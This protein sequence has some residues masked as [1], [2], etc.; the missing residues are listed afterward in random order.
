[1]EHWVLSQQCNAP[2]RGEG[3]ARP[4]GAA[5]PI[6]LASLRKVQQRGATCNADTGAY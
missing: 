5:V 1:M 3:R 4:G 2:S 6:L